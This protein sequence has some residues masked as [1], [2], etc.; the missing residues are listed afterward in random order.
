MGKKVSNLTKEKENLVRKQKELQSDK[1]T[2]LSSLRVVIAD[3]T[4]AKRKLIEFEQMQKQTWVKEYYKLFIA[5]IDE[6]ITPSYEDQQELIKTL[7][8]KRDFIKD[9]VIEVNKK[10]TE[11]T[12]SITELKRKISMLQSLAG[13]V[14]IEDTLVQKTELDA[15]I[16]N[17]IVKHTAFNLKTLDV[18]ESFCEYTRVN[19]KWYR[20]RENDQSDKECSLVKSYMLNKLIEDNDSSS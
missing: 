19:S 8:L 12:Q 9:S 14:H 15:G 20:I 2:L 5:S 16:I 13:R 6:I 10:I 7:E 18:F 4:N 17:V 1:I 11:L 3:I